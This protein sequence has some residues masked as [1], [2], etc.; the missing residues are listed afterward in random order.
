MSKQSLEV[1]KNAKSTYPEIN[2]IRDDLGALKKDATNLARHVRDDA[3]DH[4]EALKQHAVDQVG[5]LVESGKDGLARL[6]DTARA[7][8]LQTVAIAFLAGMILSVI[9]GRR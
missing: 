8:P 2:D 4:T 3:L 7:R 9:A 1:A 5:K 6:E